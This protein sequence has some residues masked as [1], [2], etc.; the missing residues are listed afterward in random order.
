MSTFAYDKLQK[1]CAEPRF[2]G[3]GFIQL[4]L[5]E[6][7]RLHIWSPN[8]PPIRSHNARIHDHRYD[9]ISEI[10]WGK[11]QHTTFDVCIMSTGNYD[12]IQ[13]D[14]ASEVRHKPGH[15][16]LDK[17]SREIKHQY[18]FAKGSSYS[19]NRH[20]FHDSAADTFTVTIMTKGA[21]NSDSFARII[22]PT[23]TKQPTHA[24]APEYQPTQKLLWQEIEFACQR[25]GFDI[26]RHIR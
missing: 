4:Y 7:K 8:L 24:F 6:R 19:F 3:N 21:E 10:L 12:M 22:V 13:L 16:L 14:G 2:H 15:I 26:L 9:M 18:C 5:S 20:L 23:G 11:L 17:Y 25:C 1:L